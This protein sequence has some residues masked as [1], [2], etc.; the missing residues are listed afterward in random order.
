MNLPTIAIV[1]RPNVGKSS[2]FNRL[3]RKKVAVVHPRSGITRD[4]NYA[5][6]DWNGVDFHL[7]DT[8]GIVP[9]SR[10]AM[11]RLIADQAEFAIH[12]ADLVLLVVD[13][14]TGSDQTDEQIARLL[15]KAGKNT[16][17]VANKADN[18]LL[19]SQIYEFMRLGLGDPFPVSATAGLNIG[20]LLDEIVKRLPA[21]EEA[22]EEMESA[23]RVA[24]VGRPNVGK[25]SF[26]NRLLGENRLIVSDVAGTT[27]DAVDTPF[28]FEGRKYVLVD[29]AGLR[30]R[31]KVS[32]NVEFY[33]NL[34]TNRTI[35]NCDVAVVL[36]DAVEGVT[37]QDQHILSDVLENRRGAV[38][39]V[40]KWDLIE[41]TDKTADEYLVRVK[42][43]LAHDSFVPV[44][45]ISALTGQ[46]VT[47]ALAIVD[48]V[49]EQNYRK[50]STSELNRFLQEVYGRR[51]PP[52]RLGKFIQ[53]KY[54]TQT[55]TAPPTFVFFT[56][57][58]ELVDKS[59]IQYLNNQLREEFGFEGVPIRLKFRRK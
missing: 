11:E 27:R 24:V 56:S 8:G 12:E 57:H 39:A 16:M 42:E 49:H 36:I 37:A 1:G 17:V 44:V 29:T 20:E 30:R 46:R 53:M 6:C 9:D 3:L 26:I 48:R 54:L 5:V 34:R 7:I 28:E 35:E 38:I 51:K 52:A 55:E 32:E 45:F 43:T 13:T 31:Y 18:E 50:L 59:Y 10:D 25:S 33:T 22:A 23:I 2:L 21:P 47:K 14:Q 41:K 58:P 4:R 19:E 15:F 40:N